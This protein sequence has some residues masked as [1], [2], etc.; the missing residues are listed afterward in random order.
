MKKLCVMLF[1]VL[2]AAMLSAC[3]HGD[4]SVDTKATDYTNLNFIGTP[5]AL[6]GGISGSSTPLTESTSVTAKHA[7]HMLLKTTVNESNLCDV[8]VIAQS[9]SRDDIHKYNVA[10]VGDNI[11]IYGYSGITGLPVSSKGKIVANVPASDCSYMVTTAGGVQGMSGGAVVND[12]GEVVGILLGLDK[13]RQQVAI[14]PVQ[15]FVN[16]LPIAMRDQ[17]KAENPDI[18]PKLASN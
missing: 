17:V 6:I 11:T 3:S 5:S 16:L 13:K 14:L 18:F 12:K 1:A 15:K 8:S 2:A 4:Y 9:N 7:A 10:N